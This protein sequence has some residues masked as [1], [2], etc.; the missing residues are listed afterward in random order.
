MNYEEML[1]AQDGTAQHREQLPLGTFYRKLIDRKYRHVVELKPSLT[2]SLGF[3]DALRRDQQASM[4]VNNAH[5]LHY[6]LHEDSG[7]IYELELQPGSYQTLA[8]LLDEEPAIVAA[9]GFV[10]DTVRTLIDLTEELHK[11]GIYQLCYAPQTVF[12]RK[13]DRQPMLLCHGS[14]FLSLKDQAA[15][16]E[17]YEQFV[18]PEVLAGEPADERSDVYA[19][20]RLIEALFDRS[21]IPYEYKSVLKK[22]TAADPARRFTSVGAIGKAVTG[23][24]GMLRTL[25]L[26]LAALAVVGLLVFLF[27]DLT[28]EATT[29]EFVDDN[30]LVQKKDPFSEDFETTPLE[31]EEEEYMDPEIA[32]YLDSIGMDEMTDEEFHA[33]ADSVKMYTQVED[34]FR[35]KFEQRATSKLKGL[36]SSQNLGS[37]ESNFISRS[38]AVVDELMNYANQLGSESGLTA[39][40]ASTLASQII[41]RVQGQLQQNITRYGSMTQSSSEE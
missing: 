24:R 13:S 2:D 4:E 35:R 17:G 6:E 31:S 9:K 34:I 30:G 29:V 20:A 22:A 28:P 10:E 21:S 1:H 3:C 33:L 37:S 12:I 18:A 36:Y 25:Y 15:F 5:Q 8:Q 40:Q 27:F 38:Q 14:S 19:L 11:K 32:M 23:K 39:D 7:G 26:G 41:S 16:Y